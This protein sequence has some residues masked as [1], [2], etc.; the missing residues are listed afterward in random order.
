LPVHN[1]HGDTGTGGET[2][3]GTLMTVV[4][5]MGGVK[6]DYLMRKRGGKMIKEVAMT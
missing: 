6:N 3:E 5:I 4:I 1:P 2:G